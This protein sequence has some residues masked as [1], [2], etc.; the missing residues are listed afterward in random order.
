MKDSKIIYVFALMLLFG[1]AGCASNSDLD[2]FSD[3]QEDEEA[4]INETYFSASIAEAM[5][6]NKSDHE[7]SGD[8]T[9]ELTESTLIQ[10]NGNSIE[11]VGSGASV[12]NTVVTIDAAGTYLIQ[13]TLSDGQLLVDTEDEE[14]VKIILNGVSIG[15]STNAPFAAMSAEKVIVYLPEG[16]FN[17]FTDASEYIYEEGEDE[18][19]AAFFSKADMTIYGPGSI[20]VTANYNDGIS[21]KDGLIINGGQFTINSADD[22]IRGKDYLVIRDGNF[23][24]NTTGD[25]FKSDNDE[26][27]DRGYILIEAGIFEV[28]TTEGD[29]FAAET[30]LMIANG[31]FEITTGN[32]SSQYDEDI[33]AKALKAGVNNLLEGGTFN[34]DSADDALHSDGNM[35]IYSGVFQ[36]ASGDDAVH[37]DEELTINGGEI[38]VNK[39]YEG[40]ESNIITINDGNIHLVASDDGINAAGGNDN[41]GTRPGQGNPF[42]SSGDSYIYFQGGYIV[43]DAGGDGID[44]NGSISMTGGTVLV[45]GPSS[46]ANGPLDYDGSFK[47]SGGFLIAAGTSNMAQAPS[48]SSEQNAILVYLNQQSANTLFTLQDASGNTL[49]SFAPSKQ[50][51]SVAF[52]SPEL[53]NGSNYNIYIGGTDTGEVSDG[54]YSNGSFSGGSLV[55]S[56]SVSKT[57]TTIR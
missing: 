45:N 7:D 3:D 30:D 8:E 18:P 57:I 27:T 17:S 53:S 50:F 51:A 31:S 20:T 32:G 42:G 47:I 28:N 46:G 54:L 49:V 9:Y 34:I 14:S 35:A 16:T 25:A 15:N 43:V 2:P 37:A 33:S 26:D 1:V 22:G 5:E 10:L 24:M 48:S 12:E 23:K 39:S 38:T 41:S 36:I 29:G 40:L 56:F 13:G 6:S 4:P 21:S 19:N 52:S 11:V 55:S 44:A